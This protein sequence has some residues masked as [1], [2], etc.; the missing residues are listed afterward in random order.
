VIRSQ[1]ISKNFRNEI[2]EPEMKPLFFNIQPIS[3]NSEKQAKNG[4]F[5][6]IFMAL[7]QRTNE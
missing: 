4:L 5:G 6:N 3:C 7:E 2:P 1:L